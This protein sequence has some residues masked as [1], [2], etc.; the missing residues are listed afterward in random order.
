[1]KISVRKLFGAAALFALGSMPQIV[2]AQEGCVV[3]YTDF[4]VDTEQVRVEA[5]AH[6]E[7]YFNTYYCAQEALQYWGYWEHTYG[8]E[9]SIQ[10]PTGNLASGIGGQESVPYGGGS[11]EA[12]TSILFVEDF[13]NYEIIWRI[14]I[15]CTIG[16]LFVDLFGD[17]IVEVLPSL[18]IPKV[19]LL[20][21][22]FD[23][24]P[25]LEINPAEN[26]TARII[27]TLTQRAVTHSKPIWATFF[28][29]RERITFSPGTTLISTMDGL[30]YEV[31]IHGVDPEHHVRHQAT[32]DLGPKLE[33]MKT[34][35][36]ALNTTT[37]N[38]PRHVRPP[39]GWVDWLELPGDLTK[40]EV[41]LAYTTADLVRYTSPHSTGGENS[42]FG[43]AYSVDG[44]CQN[45][46]THS[47]FVGY[48]KA[49]IDS[50]VTTLVQAR[51]LL[52]HD[53]RD[54]DADNIGGI[55]DEIESYADSQGVLVLY[56]RVKDIAFLGL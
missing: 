2:R 38:T 32:V 29:E 51:I 50:A 54:A 22:T 1:M 21:L 7:D 6:V 33:W 12:S 52:M 35:I 16:Q 5:W 53:I 46:A 37:G 48:A 11:G 34:T 30:R 36:A 56:V 41:A 27:A 10:S 40:T 39:Y 15:W 13:G 23:D 24:G 31:A 49:A 18:P 3:A 47:Q 43:N 8:A 19:V 45:C 14:W 17:D 25:H 9:I 44:S 26:R 55:I 42:W 20:A 28:V 4:V